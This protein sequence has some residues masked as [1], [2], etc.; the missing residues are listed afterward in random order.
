MTITIFSWRQCEVMWQLALSP[1]SKK[2]G[3]GFELLASLDL[4]AYQI[5]ALNLDLLYLGL[6]RS[7]SCQCVKLN[8]ALSS[9]SSE[10]SASAELNTNLSH[11]HSTYPDIVNC[12]SLVVCHYYHN[13]PTLQLLSINILYISLLNVMI[14][15]DYY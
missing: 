14:T 3:S 9:R 12:D 1:R 13:W 2:E 5:K 8:V 15:L 6:W 11:L 10:L 7:S 4:P